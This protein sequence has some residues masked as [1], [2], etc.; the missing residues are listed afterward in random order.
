MP[1]QPQTLSCSD[2]DRK[3]LEEWARSRTQEAR[4]V[5]RARIIVQCLQGNS[6]SEIARSLKVRPNTV[7]DW[8]RRFEREGLAGLADRARS[9][10]PPRYDADFR[11]KVL[12][13]LEQLPP[14]GQ[15][16]W[17]G[18]A[19]ARHLK[20]SVHAVWRVLRKEGVCLSRQRSWCVSTDPEFSVK[21]ADIVGLY[22]N[23]PEKALVISVDEKPS[24][25]ALERATGYVE[26]DSGKIVRGFKSTYKRHGTLN[27]FAALEVATGAIHTQIPGKSAGW[28]SW[29]SWIK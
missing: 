27:L 3:V 18:P 6:V 23:P 21:A 1:K 24:I 9:G 25:Q 5:E 11:K 4:L 17:D 2:Q 29:P 26:T 28:S 20:T 10:K 15:A 8:R 7:I 22:L 13:V 14:K 19:I 16:V 12:A